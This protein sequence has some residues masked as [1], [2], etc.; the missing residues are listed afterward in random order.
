MEIVKME[1]RKNI[2]T[3]L[4]YS[5]CVASMIFLCMALFPTLKNQSA[6]LG[7][8]YASMGSFSNAFGMNQV[9]I[10]SAMGYFAIECGTLLGLGG[11]LYCGMLGIGILLNEQQ[12]HTIE[13]LYTHPKTRRRILFEK[14]FAMVLCIAGFYVINFLTSVLSLLWLKESFSMNELLSIFL[15]QFILGVQ[16]AGICFGI[17]CFFQSGKLF[18]GIGI[19]FFFYCMDLYANMQ[20]D[21]KIIR[22]L[23][24]FS[25]ANPVTVISKNVWELKYLIVGIIETLVFVWI[26]KIYFEKKD[27]SS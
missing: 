24:P 12:S 22:F 11:A 21:A 6:Q 14:F 7:E 19:G 20:N 10:V 4:L 27:F 18:L 9:N 23:T 13:F 5:I 3:M 16:I 26:G 8:M 25:Y 1:C 15:L 2:K 17:S